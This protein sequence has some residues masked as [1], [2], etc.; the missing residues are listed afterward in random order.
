MTYRD[1]RACVF[2]RVSDDYMHRVRWLKSIKASISFAASTFDQRHCPVGL[3][4]N[5]EQACEEWCA[6]SSSASAS[7]YWRVA[8][9][10]Y[11]KYSGLCADMVRA[12]LK[13]PAK[14]KARTREVVFFRRADWKDGQPQKQSE[15][16]GVALTFRC[17]QI[18]QHISTYTRKVQLNTRG[19]YLQ[20]SRI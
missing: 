11:L 10:S 16:I 18:Q 15:L 14:T 2:R 8:G 20:S 12:A 17:S 6:M 9:M 5:L 4:L 1:F 3:H 19:L 13:E 7:A